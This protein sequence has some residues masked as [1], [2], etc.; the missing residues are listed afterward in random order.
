MPTSV[1]PITTFEQARAV[2]AA[3][4]PRNTAQRHVHSL[5]NMQQLLAHIGNPHERLRV[6]HV[7]GTSGKT[8]TAYYTAALLHAT[9]H[10]V[11][12]TVSPHVDEI[13]E[14]VQLGMLP[15]PEAEFCMQLSRFFVLLQKSPVRPTYFELMVAF[16]LWYFAAQHVDYAV[17][18][19]GVGGLLD[20]TN[21][22]TDPSKVCVI[23]DIGLDHT[24]VLGDTLGQIAAQK[25]GI[26]HRQNAAFCYQQSAE[27]MQPIRKRAVEQGANLTI[28]PQTS[29][30]E[31]AFLPQFQQRNFGLAL[32][33][34]Q[35]VLSRDG[36][37][38]LGTEQIL[39]A[40]RT[41]V[42]ARMEIRSWHDKV[43]ILD[44]AHNPQK[45][46]A[47]V[48]SVQAKF[49]GQSIA[50]MAGFLRGHVP[51]K[52]QAM[53][54]LA[55]HLIITSFPRL[56]NDPYSSAPPEEIATA[57]QQT[58][59]PYELQP[60]IAAALQTLLHRPEPV[61]VITGSFYLLNHVRPLLAE[62]HILQA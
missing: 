59:K 61:V 13:N 12:L 54:P 39:Q 62:R 19:V 11:G 21:V 51:E 34:V 42:P 45:L 26:M 43:I 47:L 15:L 57:Y 31:A 10:R 8:S 6:I 53:A 25:A 32:C 56:P 55:D 60:D 35:F 3:Y 38:P 28:V 18:E 16:A 9:G 27:I 44:A 14:R 5:D 23:T 46:Q 48:S 50:V 4:W 33:A 17:V 1:P 7:A 49:A 30:P 37:Q 22:I 29:L 20:S 36:H 40:A 2:L 52:V 24:K 41:T 58:S